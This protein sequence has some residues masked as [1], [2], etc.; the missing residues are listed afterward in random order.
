[1]LIYKNLGIYLWSHY[2][3]KNDLCDPFVEV[4][5]KISFNVEITTKIL[6]NF[7]MG[8]LTNDALFIITVKIHIFILRLFQ[9]VKYL[10]I[11]VNF[12]NAT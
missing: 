1:M 3:G 10:A 12:A 2:W 6:F 8:F 4:T 5:T 7:E 11:R 9:L